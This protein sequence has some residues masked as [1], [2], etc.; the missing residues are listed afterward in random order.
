LTEP[1]SYQ[2]GA[3]KN[4]ANQPGHTSFAPGQVLAE[5]YKVDYILGIGGMGVVYRVEQIFL[6]KIF[7]MKTLEIEDSTGMFWRRFQQE[8]SAVSRLDHP[9]IVKIYDF[10]LLE[11]KIPYYVMDFIDGTSLSELVKKRGSLEVEDALKIFI[12]V[13]MAL[14]HAHESDI[15]HRDIKPSNIMLQ[16]LD[17]GNENCVKLVDFGIAKL[18]TEGN[19]LQNLTRTG[20]IFGSP[21]YMSPEQCLGIGVDHRTDI[22][23]FGCALFEALT[24]SPPHMGENSLSTMIKH[25][26]E[27]APTLNE[28]SL[29]KKFPPALESVVAQLLQKNPDERYQSFSDITEDLIALS[30]GKKP[31]HVQAIKPGQSGKLK[32]GAASKTAD[33]KEPTSIM[34]W[35]LPL[36]AVIVMAFFAWYAL[37][38]IPKPP[39]VAKPVAVAV[40]VVAASPEPAEKKPDTVPISPELQ[41]FYDSHQLEERDESNR[42]YNHEAEFKYS[43]QC[44]NSAHQTVRVFQFPNEVSLGKIETEHEHHLAQGDVIISDP[45]PLTL[46]PSFACC[47]RSRYL[48]NFRSDEISY[49]DISH[50]ESARDEVLSHVDKW[51]NLRFLNIAESEITDRGLNYLSENTSLDD[52]RVA[53]TAVTGKAI[54]ALKC[55]H[56]LQRFEAGMLKEAPDLLKALRGSTSLQILTMRCSDL[57]D[58]D[59]RSLSKITSLKNI[60]ISENRK[61]T[62]KGLQYLNLPNLRGL[63]VR[64]CAIT[65][66]SFP[67]LKSLPSLK[68]ICIADDWSEE[69]QARL[70]QML[71]DLQIR[72]DSRIKQI[73][74]LMNE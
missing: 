30:K 34:F 72:H 12:R 7:A 18:K 59:L 52:L 39:A 66:A 50:K 54:A 60:D 47:E 24:G 26:E 48:D 43:T 32:T 64:Q 36:T 44:V 29:G 11:G 51:T 5:R 37:K 70:Q 33:A 1:N 27:I 53:D 40:A 55:L 41:E 25:R 65:E 56:H 8:G 63:A 57:T 6:R 14:Q 45:G 69:K 58:N 17:W 73:N 71:P 68:A 74:K 10:G 23:S 20:D 21:L 2:T 49:L 35:L 22:Y 3:S 31:T 62:D 16:S 28:G 38:P 42:C 46:T 4:D 19:E 15:V 13:G 61:I 9:N 67:F